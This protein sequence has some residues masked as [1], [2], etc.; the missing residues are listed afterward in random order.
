MR[1]V[2]IVGVSSSGKSTLAREIAKLNQAPVVELDSIHWQA[3]WQPRPPEEFRAL[4]LPRLETESW[5]VDGNYSQVR[6]EVWRRADTIIWVHIPFWQNLWAVIRRTGQRIFTREKLWAD[7]R[8]SLLMQL[9][10]ESIVRWVWNTHRPYEERYRKAFREM[11]LREDSPRHLT[12]KGREH[13]RIFLETIARTPNHTVPEDVLVYPVRFGKNA[14]AEILV[15]RNAKTGLVE[16][17]SDVRQ[18][19]EDPRAVAKR[20]FQMDGWTLSQGHPRR[21]AT[22][23]TVVRVPRPPAELAV[24]EGSD[25][26]MK[27]LRAIGSS[28][29]LR[30]EFR[31]HHAYWAHIHGAPERIH[32]RVTDANGVPQESMLFWMSLEKAAKT[33]TKTAKDFLPELK[34]ALD[35]YRN[36]CVS[37]DSG[38]PVRLAK[39]QSITSPKVEPGPPEAGL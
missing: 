9:G 31:F 24:A 22:R 5:I 34:I 1:R 3:G 4:T 7:N 16:V 11:G 13:A 20:E 35:D 26:T 10:K 6:A 21:F 12:L 17:M 37:L 28:P 36:S 8:E 15:F 33:M 32:A 23:S 25:R 14:E 2:S 39:D 18:D 19:T 27:S 38:S 30:S 29:R